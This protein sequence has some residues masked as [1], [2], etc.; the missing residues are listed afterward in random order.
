VIEVEG[1]VKRYG[2]LTA[3][4]G[5]SFKVVP[6]EVFGLLGPN[7]AGKST[8]A[9]ILSGLLRP[10]EG[11]V[12]VCGVSVGEDPLT[13]RTSFAYLPEESIL[14]DPLTAREHLDHFAAL[15]GVDRVAAR[16]RAERLLEFLDLAHAADRA[17]GTYSRGMRR[18]TSIALTVVGD[19]PVFLFD[20]PTGGLDPDGAYRFAELL[21]ELRRREKT[22]I[23]QS[24]I[25]GMVEKR[26]DRIGILDRGKLQ[27]C[28]T[29]AELRE[30]AD[31]PEADLED[32]FLALTGRERKDAQGVLD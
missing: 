3:L 32:L 10:D 18:K 29:L 1:V 16:S 12:R 28:G 22:V 9:K 26:C 13:A 31:L 11:Q 20:E 14:Y 7:G 8:L 6:G 17:V 4:G 2:E 5:V 27:A 25:L 30:Q 19:P 24:H 21:A 15:R 23:V